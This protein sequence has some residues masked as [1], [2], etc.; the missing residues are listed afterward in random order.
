MF[1]RY[2]VLSAILDRV[3]TLVG[4]DH[5]DFETCKQELK[6]IG[7]TA[8]SLFTTGEQNKI[9]ANAMQEERNKFKDFIQNM[10]VQDLTSIEPLAHRRRLLAADLFRIEELCNFLS[11]VVN[12]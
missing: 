7:L 11:N 12:R 6:N 3:E 10:S 2:N 1:P 8:N 9:A 4:Q 5:F